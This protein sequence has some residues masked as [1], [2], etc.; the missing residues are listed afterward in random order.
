MK[1]TLNMILQFGPSI[2]E[3]IITIELN[4]NAI[5]CRLGNDEKSIHE[6]E[7]INDVKNV[8]IYNL[9]E[10]SKY[11]VSIYNRGFKKLKSTKGLT[12][13]LIITMDDKMFTINGAVKDES[14]NSLWVRLVR[15]IRD[16]VKF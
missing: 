14:L 11:D 16:I 13:Q 3:E 10:L 8:I 2:K 7:I 4:N 6:H 12:R 15:Q 5:H 1:D 9:P